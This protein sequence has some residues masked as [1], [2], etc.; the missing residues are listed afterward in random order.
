MSEPAGPAR[1]LRIALRADASPAIGTGHLMRCLTLADALAQGGHETRFVTRGEESAALVRA[2]GH[3]CDVLTEARGQP[4]DQDQDQNGA[5]EAGD[6]A[7][8]HWLGGSQQADARD[9]AAL[10]GAG[11]DWL[12][13]DHYAL[14]ARWEKVVAAATG[15]RV[16]AI[17]DIAD[18]RHDCAILLDQNL[19]E[20]PGRYDALVPGDCRQLIGPR[21]ALLG[22][23][24]ARL[25]ADPPLRDGARGVIYL[26]GVDR[27]GATMLALGALDRAGLG[28]RPVDVVIGAANPRRAAI[29][30]WCRAHPASTLHAGGADMAALL[31]GAGWAIGAAGAS[32]WERCCLGVPT[33]LLTIADNQRPGAA[34]LGAAG[35]ALVAGEVGALDAGSLAAMI[36]VLHRA[37]GLAGHIAHQAAALVDGAGVGR[38]VRALA[39]PAIRLRP[40]RADDCERIWQWRNHPAT[41]AHVPDPAPIALADHRRWFEGILAGTRPTDLL[42][43]ET[44]DTAVGVLRFDHAPVPEPDAGGAADGGAAAGR[45]AATVSIYLVP[46]RAAAPGSG[47]ALLR[48]GAAWLARE[49]PAT[50]HVE[51]LILSGNKASQGA[52]AGAGYMPYA[53]LWRRAIGPAE[54]ESA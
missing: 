40:A 35:A 17:D 43:G 11:W 9:S 54:S 23:A 41:R 7:H 31:A 39:A 52:F 4:Q 47:Q 48:A 27:P 19:Q 18:R 45:T 5:D 37:D 44:G 10:L 16:L 49:R 34:A 3:A 29:A 46:G 50:T 28:D 14:D 24:F 36:A 8:S 42:I 15:A 53:G 6:L 21:Y 13:V 25:R 2:R 33:I 20:R 1:R 51:A 32:A 38:V 30:D 22:P 26:G 12:V